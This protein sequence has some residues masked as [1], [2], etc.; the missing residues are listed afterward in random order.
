MRQHTLRQSYKLPLTVSMHP[1]T[2]RAVL[3]VPVRLQQRGPR[4]EPICTHKAV[5]HA[6]YGLPRP[7]AAHPRGGGAA[8]AAPTSSR[9]ASR[10]RWRHPRV[11]RW[12][13]RRCSARCRRRWALSRAG[14]A[15][16]GGGGAGGRVGTGRAGSGRWGQGRGEAWR[17]GGGAAVR[18]CTGREWCAPGALHRAEEHADHRHQGKDA[19]RLAT[20]AQARPLHDDVGRKPGIRPQHAADHVALEGL[21]GLGGLPGACSRESGRQ[22]LRRLGRR[23]SRVGRAGGWAA[24][25]QRAHARA[26]S[27]RGRGS[28]RTWAPSLRR[29]R[30]CAGHPAPS[31]ARPSGCG[32]CCC[33]RRY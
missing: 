4:P 28:G 13:G 23:A 5:S 31:T 22:A 30:A 19:E 21:L 12:R 24:R 25:V 9:R 15:D 6:T 18:V 27:W 32:C 20:L 11:G 7:C 14:P 8:P 33:R 16:G 26:S 29:A 3:P 2:V 1:V 17:P 10:G